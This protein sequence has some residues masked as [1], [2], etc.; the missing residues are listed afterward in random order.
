MADK[1]KRGVG[2]PKGSGVQPPQFLPREIALIKALTEGKTIAAAYAAAGYEGVNANKSGWEALKK[3]R[4][5][6]PDILNAAGLGQHELI[7]NFLKPM[8]SATEVKV[9]KANKALAADAEGN[10]VEGEEI[11]YSQPLVAWEPRR[12]ALDMAF[13][14]HSAYPKADDPTGSGGTTN[15]TVVIEDVA[16]EGRQTPVRVLTTHSEGVQ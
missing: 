8:L 14:L 16:N 10:I 4:M 11:I 6:A 3:I 5:K 12:A 2:R 7:H 15:I 1:I 9:F 13:K